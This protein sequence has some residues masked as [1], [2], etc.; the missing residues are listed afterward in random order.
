[1]TLEQNATDGDAEVVISAKGQDEGFRRIVV[2]AP[3]GHRVA[4]LRGDTGAC[5]RAIVHRWA[6][7]DDASAV[8][9]LL[10]PAADQP[11]ATARVAA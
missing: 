10:A 3:D 7:R 2:T 9:V 11:P 1:L 5:G 8:R 4:E 6:Q